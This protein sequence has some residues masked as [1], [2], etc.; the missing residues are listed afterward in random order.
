MPRSPVVR[1]LGSLKGNSRRCQVDGIKP[2]WGVLPIVHG[3]SSSSPVPGVAQVPL[4]NNL[5]P[6]V[7]RAPVHHR[8]VLAWEETNP[9]G[10]P[11]SRP[12]NRQLRSHR[13]PGGNPQHLLCSREHQY[14]EAC[15]GGRQYKIVPRHNNSKRKPKDLITENSHGQ[16]VAILTFENGLDEAR[17]QSGL[18]AVALLLFAY[19]YYI[20]HFWSWDLLIVGI[21]IVVVK[22]IV[23]TWYLITD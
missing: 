12:S 18:S 3:D 20:D 23:L 17:N 8:R 1:Q 4:S 19:H 7:T 16:P 14:G 9:V 13:T 5:R 6:G 10:M 21:T 2:V 22:W 15:Q 11:L